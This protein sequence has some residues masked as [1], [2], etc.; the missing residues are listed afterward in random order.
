MHIFFLVHN[1]VFDLFFPS[2]CGEFDAKKLQKSNAR[3]VAPPPP[4]R[5]VETNDGALALKFLGSEDCTIRSQ[6]CI[7]VYISCKI[8]IHETS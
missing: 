5:V 3:G 7:S 2:E 4:S 1:T 8:S 6:R